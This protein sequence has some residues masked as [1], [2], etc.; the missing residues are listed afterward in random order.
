LRSLV[1]RVRAYLEAAFL[2]S[3]LLSRVYY[4]ALAFKGHFASPSRSDTLSVAELVE[5]GRFVVMIDRSAPDPTKDSGSVRAVQIMNLLITLGYKVIFCSL[6]GSRI[7]DPHVLDNPKG[8]SQISRRGLHSLLS[9]KKNFKR[10]SIFWVSRFPVF[11][12]VVPNLRG[13]KGARIIFD[14][15]DLHGLRLKR[16]GISLGDPLLAGLGEQVLRREVQMAKLAEEVVVVSTFEKKLLDGFEIRSVL[17][18][19]IHDLEPNNIP[20][21]NRVGQVF[22]G[23]FNHLPNQIS[24]MW[25]LDHVWSI[26]PRSIRLEGLKVIGAPKPRIGRH[27]LDSDIELLGWIKNPSHEIQ[28]SKVSVAPIVAGAGVKGKIGQAMALGTPVVTTSIGA[29]GMGLKEGLEL[30]VSD[31][32]EGFADS[33]QGL[34]LD[35]DRNA[36][37]AKS[38]REA[39][40]K[41]YSRGAALANLKAILLGELDK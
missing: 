13:V 20:W 39:I 11:R 16:L 23:N 12:V 33:V 30:E 1:F 28:Q 9:V 22:I 37:V 24:L 26:L 10:D 32:A 29:E 15:V 38:G 35:E 5:N 2:L 7:A 40:Q 41:K 14:T 27:I 36:K 21:C 8:L 18:T 17:V 6:D 31:S 25:Y 34:M 4:A 19:N 3:S